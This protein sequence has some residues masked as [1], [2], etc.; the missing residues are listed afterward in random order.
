MFINQSVILQLGS[1]MAKR[2]VL[3]MLL[4]N[5]FTINNR[6]GGN[7]FGRLLKLLQQANKESKV[8]VFK[9]ER[10]GELTIIMGIQVLFVFLYKKK[11]RKNAVCFF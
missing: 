2:Q 5:A 3:D 1:G 8:K 6:N 7:S 9:G 4:D 11:R 10:D